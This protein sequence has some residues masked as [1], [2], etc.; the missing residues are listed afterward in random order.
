MVQGQAPTRGPGEA[1]TRGPR[2]APTGLKLQ[3]LLYLVKTLLGGRNY[4]DCHTLKHCYGTEN[5]I[6]CYTLVEK[7]LLRYRHYRGC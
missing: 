1:P 6:D 5:Y 4:I 2:E 3:T 7:T